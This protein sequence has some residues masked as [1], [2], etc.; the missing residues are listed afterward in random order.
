MERKLLLSIGLGLLVVVLACFGSMIYF[1]YS[2]DWDSMYAR[3]GKSLWWWYGSRV[4]DNFLLTDPFPRGVGMG[5]YRKDGRNYTSYSVYVVAEKPLI[6]V[7]SE[8]KGKLLM[9]AKT[10]SG[11]RFLVELPGLSRSEDYL[12]KKGQEAWL[13]DIT[14][15]P[16]KNAYLLLSWSK[17]D[18]MP[19]VVVDSDGEISLEWARNHAAQVSKVVR[20]QEQ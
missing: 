6:G 4:D 12:P 7:S 8:M 11:K 5:R 2:N 1:R 9:G 16:L 20:F 3:L 17:Y 10:M 18:D 15:Y 13:L 14:K 19:G